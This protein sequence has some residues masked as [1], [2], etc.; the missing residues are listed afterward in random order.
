MIYYYENELERSLSRFAE[1]KK[2]INKAAI[3]HEKVREAPDWKS[4]QFIRKVFCKAHEPSPYCVCYSFKEYLAFM[5][6]KLIIQM[7]TFSFTVLTEWLNNNE[8]YSFQAKFLSS[9][10]SSFL[11][12]FFSSFFPL[13]LSIFFLFFTFH[14]SFSL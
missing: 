11:F 3:W 9:V 10:L 1:A 14:P 7:L 5:H 4:A 12:Y 2:D 6:F 8:L 13:F